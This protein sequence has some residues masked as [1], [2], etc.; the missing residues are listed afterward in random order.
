MP[1]LL[2]TLSANL[3]KKSGS[4]ALSRN[5]LIAL[6]AFFPLA[7]PAGAVEWFDQSES[8]QQEPCPYILYWG[9]LEARFT[10]DKPGDGYTSE[11]R[12]SP[13]AVWE[14][15]KREP[16]L[17][18]GETLQETLTLEVSGITVS[19]DYIKPE[20]YQACLKPLQGVAKILKEG[21]RMIIEK[22]YLPDGKYGSVTLLIGP[23]EF[24]FHPK[25]EARR[26]G[27][28]AVHWGKNTFAQGEKRFMT[29]AEFWDMLLSEPQI[30]YTNQTFRKPEQWNVGIFN[31]QDPLLRLWAD[32]SDALNFNQLRERLEEEYDNIK[33]GAI[34]QFSAWG[35]L[36]DAPKSELDTF[37]ISDPLTKEKTSIVV[38]PGSGIALGFAAEEVIS[39]RIISDV[40]PRRFLKREDQ[41]T[42][43]IKWGVFSES[44]PKS[45]FAQAYYTL[46][47]TGT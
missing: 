35:I 34:I 21:D 19:S 43:Q 7:I 36:D 25:S 14:A 30:E 6:L 13:E 27:V 12:I 23:S 37:I 39:C 46:D 33:P 16:R 24:Q 22:I 20:V 18:N 40:D 3:L 8:T 44:I 17:W 10:Y 4:A 45:V 9:G 38:Y 11:M 1:P 47:E 32:R 5:L 42:Y 29:V 28:S 26:Y 15:I 41:H 2:S 31:Q